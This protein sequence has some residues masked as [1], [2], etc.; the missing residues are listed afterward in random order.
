MRTTSPKP[1]TNSTL[2][3]LQLLLMAPLASLMLSACSAP[4]KA[5]PPDTV[6]CPRPAKLSATVLQAMRPDSTEILQR[7][8]SWLSRSAL[9]LSTET[10]ESNFSPTSSAPTAPYS[11]A[12]TAK[13]PSSTE[14]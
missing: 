9:S 10:S 6:Q 11:A 13:K 2:R 7:V 3:G 5:A 14:P 8:D 4:P 12:A 1:P